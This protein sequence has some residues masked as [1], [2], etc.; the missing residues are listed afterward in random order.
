[1]DVVSSEKRGG[2][3]S[4]LILKKKNSPRQTNIAGK[5]IRFMIEFVVRR[6]MGLWIRF[7]NSAETDALEHVIKT[8]TGNRDNRL[9]TRVTGRRYNEK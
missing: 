6:R 1:M 5:T 9:Q 7:E 2:R 3:M 4:C 8:T